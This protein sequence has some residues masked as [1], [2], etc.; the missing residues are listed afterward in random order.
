MILGAP[1]ALSVRR[2]E[3]EVALRDVARPLPSDASFVAPPPGFFLTGFWWCQ[4]GIGL[5]ASWCLFSSGGTA[6]FCRPCCWGSTATFVE[7]CCSAAGCRSSPWVANFTAFSRCSTSHS[8]VIF[9]TLSS[10][11]IICDCDHRSLAFFFVRSTRSGSIF[12]GCQ[13]PLPVLVFDLHNARSS[14]RADGPRMRL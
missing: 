9:F 5:H 8:P 10:S 4:L 3:Y 1:D 6:I 12:I 13:I 2:E 11:M 7:V 14:H